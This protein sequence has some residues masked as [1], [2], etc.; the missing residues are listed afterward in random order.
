MATDPFQGAEHKGKAG[1]RRGDRLTHP[2]IGEC[3]FYKHD[4][5]RQRMEVFDKYG[6]IRYIPDRE[7]DKCQRMNSKES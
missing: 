5:L 7:A 2:R 4:V 6:I 3:E 1:Y